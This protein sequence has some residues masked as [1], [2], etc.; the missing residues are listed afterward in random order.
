MRPSHKM[1]FRSSGVEKWSPGG[2]K[3]R[4]SGTKK[5]CSHKWFHM[6]FSFTEP[7]TDTFCT[8]SARPLKNPQGVANL[9]KAICVV[10]G[11]SIVGVTIIFL[12]FE[13]KSVG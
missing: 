3:T 8:S 2:G 7:Y 4:G 9:K 12:L 11:D 1:G 10:R 6:S 13:F 5:R